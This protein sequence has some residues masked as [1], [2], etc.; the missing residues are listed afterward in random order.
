MPS[1]P[2]CKVTHAV[3][4]S[5]GIFILCSLTLH[6]HILCVLHLRHHGGAHRL[7][8]ILPPPSV[9]AEEA[10]T[11]H[12]LGKKSGKGSEKGQTNRLKGEIQREKEGDGL[13]NSPP[14]MAL[15]EADLD[16]FACLRAPHP[17]SPTRLIWHIAAGPVPSPLGTLA[18]SMA[19]TLTQTS[20]SSLA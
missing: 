5:R 10:R 6:P 15:C 20:S 8:L 9:A 3:L 13:H 2:S 14:K 16:A 1:S 19:S 17:Y 7:R 18:M 11:C 4:L 12:R